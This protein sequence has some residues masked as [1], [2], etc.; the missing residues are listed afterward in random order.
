MG[1]VDR[2]TVVE[3]NALFELG[4]AHREAAVRAI[5]SYRA[6]QASL[7]PGG[8]CGAV[9]AQEV[10]AALAQAAGGEMRAVSW[11]RVARLVEEH[12]LGAELYGA[13]HG[14]VAADAVGDGTLRLA[15]PRLSRESLVALRGEGRLALAA[16]MAP[17]A[18]LYLLARDGLSGVFDA[19]VA[20]VTDP[21][22]AGGL[23]ALVR[24]AVL[25]L[26]SATPGDVAVIA[27]HRGD[28]EELERSSPWSVVCA[29]R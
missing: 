10:C 1:G 5:A 13:V 6:V 24:E 22:S 2:V 8:G 3:L 27:A 4:E 9:P 28:A 29:A 23:S 25:R 18:V 16:R 15:R 19:V 11:G 14:A 26:A 17:G 12:L 21:Q 20:R 7:P